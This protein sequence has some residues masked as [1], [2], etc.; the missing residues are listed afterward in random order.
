MR[1]KAVFLFSVLFLMLIIS[2]AKAE[3]VKVKILSTEDS[4]SRYLGIMINQQL[5]NNWWSMKKYT[6]NFIVLKEDIG[7]EF[8]CE[9]PKEETFSSAQVSISSASF[10][11]WKIN[12]TYPDGKEFTCEVDR[13]SRCPLPSAPAQPSVTPS[14]KEKGK[15]QYSGLT[16]GSDIF[17]FKLEKKEKVTITLTMDENVDYD[18]CV[19]WDGTLPPKKFANV[20]INGC[21]PLKTEKGETESCTSEKELEPGTYYF[22]VNYEKG[23]GKYYI[24]SSV[25]VRLLSFAEKEADPCIQHRSCTECNTLL[26][27]GWCADD[28]TCRSSDITDVTKPS[29]G[30]CKN[31]IWYSTGCPTTTT[32]TTTTS[33]TLPTPS[34]CRMENEPCFSD[35]PNCCE[36]LRCLPSIKGEV[37]TCQPCR[38]IY[39]SC[40]STYECCEGLICKDGICLSPSPTTSTTTIQPSDCSQ[41]K[42]CEEC[43][44]KAG[45]AWCKSSNECKR[46]DD[47]DCKEWIYIK[48]FCPTTTSS[49]TTTLPSGCPEGTECLSQ[50]TCA[51]LHG[52]CVGYSSNCKSENFECCCKKPST[53]TK[54]EDVGGVCT[55][56]TPCYNQG[57]ICYENK[58][59]CV[60]CCCIKRPTPGCDENYFWN[61]LGSKQDKE[62]PTSDGKYT[63]CYKRDCILE[64]KNVEGCQKPPEFSEE[65]K[66]KQWESGYS[67]NRMF[68][69][70]D[71][72]WYWV[73]FK[74]SPTSACGPDH[75]LDVRG[76]GEWCIY[77][78]SNKKWKWVPES[79][80]PKEM[81]CGNDER[82]ERLAQQGH[83]NCGD[84]ISY[85][86]KTEWRCKC[87][88]K[89]RP[90]P[91]QYSITNF[92]A[93]TQEAI[94]NTQVTFHVYSNV[95]STQTGYYLRIYDKS[96]STLLT[97]CSNPSGCTFQL[98]SSTPGTICYLAQVEDSNGNVVSST[99]TA[100]VNWK[101]EQMAYRAAETFPTFTLT[102]STSTLKSVADIGESVTLIAY[103]NNNLRRF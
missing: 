50:D 69:T 30:S 98:T 62:E 90:S 100:C 84:K 58:F 99:G 33:T 88:D 22:R 102:L 10:F 80:V 47:K 46:A 8:T 53:P 86:D 42:T 65:E 34:K 66:R 16:V 20:K 23:S 2:I 76:D 39:H 54:C 81:C 9:V 71:N 13:N 11:P 101:A 55:G 21:K 45:C 74:V 52:S 38:K 48:E 24:Y 73:K 14:K 75:C 63:V 3:E 28:S 77:D 26:T 61:A 35:N 68:C 15:P 93:D 82:C 51:Q 83:I 60:L 85:C 92:Y 31:W 79:S 25:P 78:T 1:K 87:S 7:K 49:T 6:C 44:A 29:V 4:Y 59:E 40:T 32:S 89:P 18:L 27:C 64:I 91:P 43:V 67:L 103:S 36:G 37:W 70:L 12:V 97:T 41:Y 19:A 94:V 17:I 72:C 56:N 96:S 5:E 95:P 57:G